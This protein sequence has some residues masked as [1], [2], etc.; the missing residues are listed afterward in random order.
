[1]TDLRVLLAEQDKFR[2]LPRD[3]DL[4]YLQLIRALVAVIGGF[5]NGL[6]DLRAPA[7][8]LP[9]HQERRPPPRKEYHLLKSVTI[10]NATIQSEICLA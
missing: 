10:S 1:M 6:P 2:I 9:H 3:P 8:R 4:R 5:S 7:N